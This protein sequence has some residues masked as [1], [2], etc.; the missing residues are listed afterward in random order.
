MSSRKI[1]RLKLKFNARPLSSL[2]PPNPSKQRK[3]GAQATKD[4]KDRLKVKDPAKYEEYV[5]KCRN[6]SKRYRQ[7]CSEEQ[8]VH[9]SH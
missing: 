4:W 5:Q 3:T 1:F 8:K 2:P 7:N 6:A 9:I